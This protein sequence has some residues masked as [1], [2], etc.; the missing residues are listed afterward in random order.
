MTHH[1]TPKMT[2]RS[3]IYYT[4]K[5]TDNINTHT[6]KHTLFQESHT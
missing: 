3:V 1:S 2:M 5:N 4:P 6:E